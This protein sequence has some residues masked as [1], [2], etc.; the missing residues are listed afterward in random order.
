LKGNH[1]TDWLLPLEIYE[2]VVQFDSDFSEQVLKHLLNLK[3]QR[4]KVAHLIEGGL[5]LLE[6]KT[7]EIIK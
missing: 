1:P 3:Q 2:L 5:E 4:P 7:K 6:T